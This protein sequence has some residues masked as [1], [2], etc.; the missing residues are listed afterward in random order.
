M[1]TTT[2]CSI[3]EFSGLGRLGK[4]RRLSCASNS[5]LD[6]KSEDE[7]FGIEEPHKP[8]L[9]SPPAAPERAEREAARTIPRP[10]LAGGAAEM[11]ADK[12]R[13]EPA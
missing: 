3:P 2:M 13:P 4:F 6:G 12:E 11:R 9:P 5:L 10:G 1:V 8:E 7:V